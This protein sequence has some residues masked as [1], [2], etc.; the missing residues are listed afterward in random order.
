GEHAVADLEPVVRFAA[1]TLLD[2]DHDL[3]RHADVPGRTTEQS[4][5]TR[6][7]VT[8]AVVAGE[9]RGR[10]AGHGQGRKHTDDD[11]DVLESLRASSETLH[12]RGRLAE[13]ISRCLQALL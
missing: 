1:R 3:V 4:G 12:E 2:R 11:E 8:R 5:V 7:F 13:G 6:C 10:R 9:A